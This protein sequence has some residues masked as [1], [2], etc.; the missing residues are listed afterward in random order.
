MEATSDRMEGAQFTFEKRAMEGRRPRAESTR[1]LMID[2]LRGMIGGTPVAGA[3][4]CGSWL[5]RKAVGIVPP[6]AVALHACALRAHSSG[7]PRCSLWLRKGNS[8]SEDNVNT[9]GV[10]RSREVE[11]RP[12]SA[13]IVPP[14]WVLWRFGRACGWLTGAS[15][16]KFRVS[17]GEGRASS[18]RALGIPLDTLRL[19][20]CFAASL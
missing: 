2:D 7:C 14:E 11:R 13:W 8:R 3:L 15:G 20:E 1:E 5:A 10:I 9:Q 17:S 18:P 16:L 6:A 12:E 19:P 4:V